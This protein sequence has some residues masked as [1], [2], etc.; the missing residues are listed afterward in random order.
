MSNPRARFATTCPIRPNPRI[1]SR[2]P[3]T[4][5]P[6]MK[7]GLQSFHAAVRTSRSPS[8]ARRAAPSRSIMVSSAVA[9]DSTSGVFVTM[10]PRAF[11]AFTSTWS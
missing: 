7:A 5:V 4:W 6:T 8:L 11:A 1:P 2:F 10:I 9:S 3:V